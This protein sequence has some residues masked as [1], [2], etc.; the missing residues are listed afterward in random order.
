MARCGRSMASLPRLEDW[1]ELG[2]EIGRGSL[3]AVFRA[4]HRETGDAVAVKL[5]RAEV[6]EGMQSRIQREARLLLGVH[7]PGL[8]KLMGCYLARDG[9]LALA[10]ELVEG[11]SLERCIPAGGA[12]LAQALCW[13]REMAVALDALHAAGLVHRDLKPANVIVDRAG[14]PRILD[15]G[16]ARPEA[17]GD[18]LTVL[19][20]V[21]GT[22]YFMA[23]EQIAGGRT[24]KASDLYALGAIVYCM[25]SGTPPF[26][27]D[28][29]E[30]LRQHAAAPPPRLT[31]V[32]P[33]LPSGLDA[34]LARAMAKERAARFPHA[35]AFV[36]ALEVVA[37]PRPSS[38]R[39]ASGGTPPRPRGRDPTRLAWAAL[40]IL[41]A[42]VAAWFA[43]LL[44]G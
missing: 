34:V 21:L 20:S 36:E 22:P 2:A 12:D 44:G 3:G 27:G 39:P 9:Q 8:V 6:S 11:T 5:S 25:L 29:E 31:T 30:V 43:G 33:D 19:G 23:P 14:R 32:R 18:T 37:G 42:A 40:G 17:S 35:V 41:A 28:T 24:R 13:A 38:Q 7:H 1:Y 26:R 4:V 15:F 16:L 10:Y